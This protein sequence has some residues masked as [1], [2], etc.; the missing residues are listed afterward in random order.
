MN[1]A[2]FFAVLCL[3]L[4]SVNSRTFPKETEQETLNRVAV[5]TDTIFKGRILRKTTVH[6]GIVYADG[7]SFIVA[8]M[9]VEV[10]KVYRGK[11]HKNDKQIM[12]TWTWHS[13][14][15]T[16]IGYSNDQELL[17]FGI[18][19]NPNLILIPDSYG[20]IMDSIEKESR[21]YKA[22]KLKHKIFKKLF[23]NVSGLKPIRNVCYE[24][25]TWP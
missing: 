23:I 14:E 2:I 21:L 20:Y 9:E 1:K 19:E 11:I 3:Y 22:L 16:E 12:C 5:D 18:R 25:V 15:V 10:L 6:D 7:D 4:S 8:I 17:F 24:P 13:P